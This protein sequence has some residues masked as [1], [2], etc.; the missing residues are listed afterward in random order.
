MKSEK[1]SS[2]T[3]LGKVEDIEAIDENHENKDNFTELSVVDGGG[4]V[5]EEFNDS[6]EEVEN[7]SL[8]EYQDNNSLTASGNSII[9]SSNNE[10]LKQY[11]NHVS[12]FPI[13]TQEEEIKM[14]DLYIDKG[15]QKAG[16]AIV[17]SHLRLVV[18]IAFQYSKFGMNMMDLISEGNVGLMVALKKFDRTKQSRFSTYASLWIRAK[19]Q[20]FILRSWNLV[21]I[22]TVSLRKQLLFNFN[23]LKKMLHINNNSDYVEQSK[24]ISKHFGISTSEYGEAVNAIKNREPSLES[25]ITND[26]GDSIALIDTISGSDGNYSQK[27]AENEEKLYKNKI[28]NESMSI[29]N[30]RQKDIIIERYLKEDKKTLEDLSKKYNISKERVRQIEES[31]IKKLKKFAEDYD[32]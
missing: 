13:L 6:F 23:G 20:D 4:S 1:H 15:D 18:K 8:V 16:Q 14:F 12:K 27:I 2:K 19:V 24:A 28:F 3:K 31:A 10:I 11:I 29:L 22:G 17:L 26:N 30:E 21:K 5:V 25:P 9:N 32:K 7:N